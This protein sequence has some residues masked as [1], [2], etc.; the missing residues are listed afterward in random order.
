MGLLKRRKWLVVGLIVVVVGA[1]GAAGKLAGNRG[2]AAPTAPAEPGSAADPVVVTADAVTA[3][4]IRRSVTAVGSLWGWEEV[5]ITPKVEGR[6]IRVHKFVG[7]VVKQGMCCL[8]STRSISS[9]P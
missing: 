6:V 4:P 9:L 7:D 2:A 3:R 5:P 8:R 1:L